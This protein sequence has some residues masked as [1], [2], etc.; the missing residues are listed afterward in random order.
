MKKLTTLFVLSLVLSLILGACQPPA[1]AEPQTVEKEVTKIVPQTIEKE[2]TKVVEITST[3]APEKKEPVTIRVWSHFA[4]EPLS[5]EVIQGVFDDYMAQHPEVNI[6]VAWFDK[7]PLR[8]SIQTVMQS[9][10]EGA[11]DITTFD[12]YDVSWVE[13]GWV[14]PL[15]DVLDPDRFVP[16][17]LLE[18]QYPQLGHPESHKLN[19]AFTIDYLL[20]NKEI[21]AELGIEVPDD[22]QFTQDEFLEV[23]KKCSDAGYAGFANGAGNRPFPGAYISKAA[24]L[25]L[26][27][28]EEFDLYWTG[29]KSWDTPEVRQ[30]LEY[31]VELGE[32]GLW[33]DSFATM[34]LDEAHLYFHT[35]RKACMF[36]NGS[37]YTSRA[38]KPESE[39][40]QSPDFRFGMLLYPEMNGSK[41]PKSMIG[42]FPTG[43]I[44]LTSS[45]HMDIAKDIL[46][47]W[48]QNPVY[49]A[50]W[51]GKTNV[52][53]A[54]V[55]EAEDIPEDLRTNP[56]QWYWDEF[57]AVYG[58]AEVT[59]PGNPCGD[60]NDT[61]TSVLNQGIPLGLI[62]VDEAIATLDSKLCK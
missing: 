1:A 12:S 20:Y 3:P 6:E 43:Y 57:K 61:L 14:A 48:V 59:V 41:A 47:F 16:G 62:S 29:Q 4:N 34:T 17:A 28:P 35:Q 49:G 32:A 25:S 30:A 22:F 26:V 9:G 42:L 7:E 58:D 21:F 38:F 31:V 55:F 54:M 15:D 45:K 39:G 11:P 53:S 37:W 50:I 44:I 19:M 18:N 24:L 46:S 13:A 10:G 5:R 27:G 51:Q 56:W 33:H 23:V 2:I 36:L 60:F 52:A 40:G 8:Q